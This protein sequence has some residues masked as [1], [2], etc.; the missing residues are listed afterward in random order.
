MK[1]GFVFFLGLLA[2]LAISF[3][4]VVIGAHKQLGGLAPYF[5]EGDSATFPARPQGV[6][7]RGQLVY[8]GLGCA[9]C[10]TPS[11]SRSP[12]GECVSCPCAKAGY[13]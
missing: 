5:D 11:A 1:N 4:G 2:A 10:H 9:S 6:A 7:A 3:G 8:A 12:S 13:A